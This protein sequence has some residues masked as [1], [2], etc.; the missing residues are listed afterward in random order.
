MGSPAWKDGG[1]VTVASVTGTHTVLSEF[2]VAQHT[3]KHDVGSALTSSPST[4]PAVVRVE[5]GNGSVT[6]LLVSDAPTLEG[7]QL[8]SRT[9]QPVVDAISPF[10]LVDAD[11]GYV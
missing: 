4:V 7:F 2:V 3:S 1:T 5:M 10:E 6:L 11:T 8:L 9:L